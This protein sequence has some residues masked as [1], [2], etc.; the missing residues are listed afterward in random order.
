MPKLGMEPKRRADVIN[1]TL[2]CISK[3]GMDGL[4]L[5]KVA[6][7]ANC[8]KR[9]VT[10]YYK[11]KDYLTIEAFKAFLAYYG[12]K[13]QAEIDSSM[14][15]HEMLNI[16]LKYILPPLQPLDKGQR[17]IN[18]SAIDGVGQM[19]IPHDDQARLFVQFFSKA[20]MAPPSAGNFVEKL[21]G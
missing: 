3:H 10:Y 20:A 11:N 6:E 12:V 17:K 19:H 4:T 7:D 15:A 1:A 14:N 2:T 9:V 18:V 16:I 5:D 21:Y 8:S 13:I